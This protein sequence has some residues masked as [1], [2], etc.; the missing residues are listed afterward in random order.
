MPSDIEIVLGWK[1]TEFCKLWKVNEP[2]G[3]EDYW[4]NFQENVHKL[5]D[6]KKLLQVHINALKRAN[7]ITSYRM[8]TTDTYFTDYIEGI[9]SLGNRTFCPISLASYGDED[10]IGDEY[11]DNFI[12]G[13]SISGRYVPTYLDWKNEHGTLYS[14]SLEEMQPLIDIIKDEITKVEPLFK[15]AKTFIKMMWY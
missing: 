11:P 8:R 2:I 13:I 6:G 9:T 1:L 15:Q 12:V 4:D 7:I 5:I 3:I 10:E 14:V